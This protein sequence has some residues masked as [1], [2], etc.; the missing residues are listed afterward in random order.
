VANLSF[1][2][3]Y[4]AMSHSDITISPGR[5]ER[6]N[7]SIQ[8]GSGEWVRDRGEERANAAGRTSKDRPGRN[9]TLCK[10]RSR[11][12]R[13]PLAGPCSSRARKSGEWCRLS[14]KNAVRSSNQCLLLLA[15][16]SCSFWA[17]FLAR[18][19]SLCSIV[20]WKKPLPFTFTAQNKLTKN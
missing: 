7:E 10:Q 8:S 11:Q 6:T 20:C 19:C 3:Y 4:Q 13:V 12:E 18:N 9:I 2:S 16:I 14:H 17:S 1:S 15:I 5:K